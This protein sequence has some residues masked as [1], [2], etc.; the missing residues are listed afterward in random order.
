M[1]GLEFEMLHLV[2]AFAAKLGRFAP[3]EEDDPLVSLKETQTK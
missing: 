1:G 3:E 2:D